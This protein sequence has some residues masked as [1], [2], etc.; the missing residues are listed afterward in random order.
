MPLQ[1]PR[2]SRGGPPGPEYAHGG[3]GRRG[4]HSGQLR[5][6]PGTDSGR[7]RDAAGCPGPGTDFHRVDPGRETGNLTCIPG[8]T[9]NQDFRIS[10]FHPPR[11]P[12][13]SADRSPDGG[14]GGDPL[15]STSINAQEFVVG[16]EVDR[17]HPPY[18]LRSCHL[19][20]D[21]LLGSHVNSHHR[22]WCYHRRIL[23]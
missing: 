11:P 14:G 12:R 13:N 1:S 22:R 2:V 16:E 9:A 17:P 4:R 5:A 15:K 7:L 6:D 8:N 18:H 3:N 19:E 10:G 23:H 21:T 20:T